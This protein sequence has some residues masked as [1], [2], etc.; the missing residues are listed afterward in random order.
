MMRVMITVNATAGQARVEAM[1]ERL[2]DFL[3]IWARVQ[4][5]WAAQN[6][7]AFDSGGGGLPEGPWRPL[8]AST[9]RSKRGGGARPLVGKGQLEAS[10]AQPGAP[11]S[12]FEPSAMGLRLGSSVP[13]A[14]FH[15]DGTRDIPA[16]PVGLGEELLDEVERVM[17][18][19]VLGEG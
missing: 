4:Q 7:R 13:H 5:A 2:R 16:R 9:V 12:I 17:L 15:Q 10:Y 1:E 8:K 11:A 3:P 18:A 6:R 19:H 14:A